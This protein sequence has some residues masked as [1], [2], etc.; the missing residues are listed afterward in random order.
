MVYLHKVG[1]LLCLL[2]ISGM[3]ESQSGERFN[4]RIESITGYSNGLQTPFWLVSNRQGLSSLTKEN[5][6]L[7]VGLFHPS[8]PRKKISF[9]YGLDVYD[10][11]GL[12]GYLL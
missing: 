7:R 4:Y 6:C 12:S 3:A 9:A 1:A 5:S 8:E 10:P 11:T 2:L